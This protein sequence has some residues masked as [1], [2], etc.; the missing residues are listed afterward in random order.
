MKTEFDIKTRKIEVSHNA[1]KELNIWQPTP[2]DQENLLSSLINNNK[3]NR[4]KK[5]WEQK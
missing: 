2:V 1:Y 4:K 5:K 3:N